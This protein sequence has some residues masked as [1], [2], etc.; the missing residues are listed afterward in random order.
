MAIEQTEHVWDI[1]DRIGTCMLTTHTGDRLRSR[2]MHAIVDREAGC[3][4]FITDQR[5][6]KEKEI[7]AS[8]EVCLAFADTGSN[9]F[10]SLTGRAEVLR[11]S[12]KAS[13]LWN[14][15]AQAW[16]PDGPTDPH[17]RVLRVTPNDAEYWDSRGNSVAVALKLAAA[18]RS[19]RSPDLAESKKVRMR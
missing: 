13:E 1:A 3:L 12:A 9:A 15:E 10:L 19:G 6:A 14:D 18:R 11:D 17:V 7:R 16:W 4:W 2:P 5:G 8:P